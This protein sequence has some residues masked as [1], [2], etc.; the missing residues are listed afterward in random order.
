MV[1]GRSGP[2]LQWTGLSCPA[3]RQSVVECLWRVGG[4][5]GHDLGGNGFADEQAIAANPDAAG[6]EDAVAFEQPLEGAGLAA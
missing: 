2:S 6:S 4:F 5:G 1:V 3:R